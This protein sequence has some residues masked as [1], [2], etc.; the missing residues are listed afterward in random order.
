MIQEMEKGVCDTIRELDNFHEQLQNCHYEPFYQYANKVT[1]S[2]KGLVKSLN[3]EFKELQLN[4]IS[5]NMLKRMGASS[6][7]VDGIQERVNDMSGSLAGLTIR[8][9]AMIVVTGETDCPN[10]PH[11]G[12]ELYDGYK[13][14]SW[15]CISIP[16]EEDEYILRIFKDFYEHSVKVFGELQ[17]ECV[18]NFL[19]LQEEVQEREEKIL[20]DGNEGSWGEIIEKKSMVGQLSSLKVDVI[21]SAVNIASSWKEGDSVGVI[22][23]SIHLVAN[24]GE[25]LDDKVQAM[26]LKSI[27]KHIFTGANTMKEALEVVEEGLKIGNIEEKEVTAAIKLGCAG[28]VLAVGSMKF[29]EFSHKPQFSNIVHG[30]GLVGDVTE[31]AR[32]MANPT[33]KSVRTALM[34]TVSATKHV[35]ALTTEIGNG[36]SENVPMKKSSMTSTPITT[37][38]VRVCHKVSHSN[39]MNI[40][41]N[42]IDSMDEVGGILDNINR[43]DGG[44][45]DQCIS[46]TMHHLVNISG[47]VL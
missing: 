29:K 25:L 6:S 27:A 38:V 30:I 46:R 11:K 14:L 5:E 33:P 19:T 17:E 40:L 35:I 41:E 21:E 12:H 37:S 32:Y 23:E 34:K 18:K 16:C 15:E 31:V 2:V 22:T 9:N 7:M 4:V 13:R 44:Y 8:S 10:I 47:G 28:V 24:I 1:E 43:V 20:S 36:I 39:V 26:P 45:I 3:N 42:Y